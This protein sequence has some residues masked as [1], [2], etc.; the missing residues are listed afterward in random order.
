MKYMI[1]RLPDPSKI[2]L[3]ADKLPPQWMYWQ[4]MDPG[5]YLR[6]Q[7]AQGMRV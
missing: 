5:D 4:E 1:S 2:V 6:Q 3:P 7:R